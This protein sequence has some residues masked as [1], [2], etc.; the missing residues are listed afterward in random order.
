MSLLDEQRTHV[1]G[2]VAELDL[3]GDRVD[4][5]ARP[6]SKGLAI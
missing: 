4:R 2:L 3:L 6:G 1:L 5:V